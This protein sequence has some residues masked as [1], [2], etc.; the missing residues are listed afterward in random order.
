MNGKGNCHHKY[1]RTTIINFLCD[2]DRDGS[3]GPEYLD[4]QSVYYL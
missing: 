1:N 4:E 3:Q 2:H